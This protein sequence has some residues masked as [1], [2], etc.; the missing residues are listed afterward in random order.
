VVR[1]AIDET[2]EEFIG[3]FVALTETMSGSSP[4]PGLARGIA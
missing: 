2:I 4:H 3:S 1:H